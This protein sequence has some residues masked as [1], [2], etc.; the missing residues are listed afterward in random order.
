MRVLERVTS[1]L[2]EQAL[3]GVYGKIFVCVHSP[4]IKPAEFRLAVA[5]V[6][7]L[8]VAL[9]DEMEDHHNPRINH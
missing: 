1:P 3:K 6:I 7:L 4:P 5:W 8:A 2:Q 9:R